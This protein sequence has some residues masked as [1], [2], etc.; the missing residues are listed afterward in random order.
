MPVIVITAF[1]LT[2]ALSVSSAQ[3]EENLQAQS[4][5][6]AFYERKAE[7]WFWY[8]WIAEAPQP[9]PESPSPPPTSASP[10]RP[11]PFSAAWFRQNL[12]R[13]KDLAWDQPTLE[14]LRA[15]LLVQRLAIDRSQQFADMSELAALGDPRLDE[16]GHRPNATF[17]TQS[18]DR[19]A[20]QAQA[21]LLNTLAQKTG[22]FFFFQS[23]CPNCALQAPLIQ[24]LADRYHFIIQPIS[25]DG[26]PL[27]DNS[28]SAFKVDQ[29]QAAKLGIQT[30]PA[31][32]LASPDGQFAAVG[33]GIMSLPELQH[34]ILVAAKRRQWV[35][36]AAFNQTRP[37]QSLDA[38][39]FGNAQ[40]KLSDAIANT[41][42]TGFIPPAQ[43][44]TYLQMP[45]FGEVK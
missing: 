23:D 12:P 5:H 28:F 39:L 13:Y 38:A 34:R 42:E 6:A 32:Y 2:L 3:A 40:T 18:F 41:D 31:L 14:N 4:T 30:L 17:A 35:S 45:A 11:A 27:P 24:S 37:V 22:L 36:D 16:L 1:L 26:K 25:V 20:G 44:E 21:A 43:L 33:Q 7:G 29:G 8:Q 10:A 9:K 15:F 19:Q